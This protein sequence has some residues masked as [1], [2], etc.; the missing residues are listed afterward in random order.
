MLSYQTCILCKKNCDGPDCKILTNGY[1]YHQI[2]F[3]NLISALNEFATKISELNR[4]QNEISFEAREEETILYKLK[5]LWGSKATNKE[6]RKI[7]LDKIN[8]QR[9][10]AVNEI[11]PIHERIKSIYDFWP[12]IPPDWE[13]RKSLVRAQAG[14]SCQKCGKTNIE[15]HVHHKIPF[16]RGGSHRP[17]NLECLCVGCHSNIHGRNVSINNKPIPAINRPVF[18]DRLELI[19]YSIDNK[20]TIIFNYQKYEGDKSKRSIK[21]IGLKQK[22]QS[23]CVEGYCYLRKAD[24]TFAI[25]RMKG[26]KISG[27]FGKSYDD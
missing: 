2:C 3:Q 13:E 26:V 19:K 7:W 1:L 15:K 10:D 6:S 18:G 27:E 9:M 4:Q 8:S 17:E 21:P 11:R 22:G 14:N 5:V 20:L 25:K 16:S 24:R 23:L 12:E